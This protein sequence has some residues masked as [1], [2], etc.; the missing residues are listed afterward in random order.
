[1]NLLVCLIGVSVVAADTFYH[2]RGAGDGVVNHWFGTHTGNNRLYSQVSPGSDTDAVSHIELVDV[3]GRRYWVLRTGTKWKYVRIVAADSVAPPPLKEWDC[4]GAAVPAPT[5]HAVELKV[6]HPT[7]RCHCNCVR[8]T[9][10][11]DIQDCYAVPTGTLPLWECLELLGWASDDR[12]QDMADADA[13]LLGSAIRAHS[14]ATAVLAACTEVG[15]GD[16]TA[17]CTS[18]LAS[19]GGDVVAGLANRT[20][21]AAAEMLA[22]AHPN[23]KAHARTELLEQQHAAGRAETYFKASRAVLRVAGLRKSALVE[24]LPLL[25]PP[26]AEAP[27][28]SVPAP[29]PREATHARAFWLR[30]VSDRA[31]VEE[32]ANAAGVRDTAGAGAGAAAAAK[33]WAASV[34]GFWQLRRVSLRLALAQVQAGGARAAEHTLLSCAQA[35]EQLVLTGVRQV[36]REAREAE[37]VAGGGKGD[38]GAGSLF[39]V[40]TAVKARISGLPYYPGK[41]TA[42]HGDGT[43][44]ILFDDGDRADRL[45]IEGGHGARIVR[46]V[47][48]DAPPGVVALA[49]LQLAVA[50]MHALR[51]ALRLTRYWWDAAAAAELYAR[52]VTDS[53]AATATASAPPSATGSDAASAG[54]QGILSS[55]RVR[56]GASQTGYRSSL[57]VVQLLRGQT[58]AAL[59]LFAQETNGDGTS[60]GTGVR[61]GGTL[62]A[63]MDAVVQPEQ[64]AGGA[65]AG[66]AGASSNAGTDLE[67]AIE[68]ENVHGLQQED[69]QLQQISVDGTLLSLCAELGSDG[70]DIARRGS[71]Y[72]DRTAAAVWRAQHELICEVIISAARMGVQILLPLRR[73]QGRRRSQLHGAAAGGHRS[74]ASVEAKLDLQRGIFGRTVAMYP[75]SELAFLCC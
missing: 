5:V 13:S 17:A 64:G 43:W 41:I 8:F 16:G 26:R 1:M 24:L 48:S 20:T 60:T 9:R 51:G 70:W 32:A 21:E 38:S 22:A 58:A 33:A 73:T 42:V 10:A 2:V 6:S 61:T 37:L 56:A 31:A 25:L 45:S 67:E 65:G 3:P 57:A 36:N 18:G 14:A 27:L 7:L 12:P 63:H 39:A 54:G 28:K 69:E 47:D 4:M 50:H 35:C 55:L 46:Q 29:P 75:A 11:Q 59:R 53:A 72:G 71:E 74:A 23:Q 52:A 62:P 30:A 34:A 44:D 15:A 40:G 49:R 66:G 68:L 19:S